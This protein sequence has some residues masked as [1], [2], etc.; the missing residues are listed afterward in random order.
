[1][2]DI[3]KTIEDGLAGIE[4]RFQEKFLDQDAAIRELSQKQV[5]YAPT[6]GAGGTLRKA[7]N[8]AR[9]QEFRADRGV[10]S[11][12]VMVPGPLRRMLTEVKAVVGDMA[13]VG[14]NLLSVQPE[15]DH[16]LGNFAMRPLSLL[17][18]LP[19]MPVGSNA[20]EYNEIVGYVNDAD[21]Q[22]NEG[23][24]FGQT[25]IPTELV[26]SKIATIG[27][28]VKLSEQV[29]ADSPA[30]LQQANAL[31]GYGVSAKASARV[32][33]GN[34]VA[35]AIQ[36]LQT[37]AATHT[38]SSGAGLADAIGQAMTALS[39]AG[40]VPDLVVMHPNDW[41]LIRAERTA[42][43]YVA[44]GWAL[45]AIPSIWGAPVVTDPAVTAGAPLVMDRS[46]VMILDRQEARVELGRTG[47]D[48]TNGMVTLRAVIRV[49]LAVFS[50]SAVRKVALA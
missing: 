20:F 36:G 42:T 41:Q 50:T 3:A 28:Y 21:Q 9:I 43:G 33:A 37:I 44:G 38:G 48:F 7:F 16:R 1:M 6:D 14:N 27:H 26:T 13:G 47:N 25:E 40:W 24:D 32:I 12:S 22:A 2:T 5:G 31:M 4:K 29:T 10:K 23:A 19:H 8:D 30:L 35:S 15:R 39:T 45:P 46:Q 17:E 49:G 11:V 34:G 18:A